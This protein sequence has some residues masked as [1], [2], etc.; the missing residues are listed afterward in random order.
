MT[1]L[2]PLPQVPGI[3]VATDLICGFPG[4]TEAHFDET[5]KLVNDYKFP[6][7]FI[8]QVGRGVEKVGRDSRGAIDFIPSC[9]GLY[10]GYRNCDT[11]SIYSYFIPPYTTLHDY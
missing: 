3:T 7:L 9:P 6:V 5:L 8:N 4:E 2:T 1:S 11:D 10:P